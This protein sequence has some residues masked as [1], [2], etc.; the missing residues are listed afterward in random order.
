MDCAPGAEYTADMCLRIATALDRWIEERPVNVSVAHT[1]NHPLADWEDFYADVDND[2]VAVTLAYVEEAEPVTAMNI[3]VG[4]GPFP[5]DDDV[6]PQPLQ[7]DT[8]AAVIA[9]TDPKEW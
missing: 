7:R 5:G 6:R 2:G 9:H 1:E 3:T 8:L 4:S